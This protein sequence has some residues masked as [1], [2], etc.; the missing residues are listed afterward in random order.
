MK[1]KLLFSIV[2]VI[3]LS[4]CT[5]FH[6]MQ[7]DIHYTNLYYQDAIASYSKVLEKKSDYAVTQRLADCYTRT[8]DKKM[9]EATWRKAVAYPQHVHSDLYKFGLALMQVKKYEEAKLVFGKYLTLV[10]SDRLA[11]HRIISCDS[12]MA[13]Q[14]DSFLYAVTKVGGPLNNEVSNYSP[15]WYGDGIVFTS[16][17]SADPNPKIAEWTHHPYTDL[18]EAKLDGDSVRVAPRQLDGTI[19]GL[20]HEG[21]VVFTADQKFVYFTRSNYLKRHRGK[22]DDYVNNLKLYQAEN[23][24]GMWM[25]IIELPFNSDE[26]SSGHPALTKDEQEMYFVSDR[27]GGFGGTDLW[28]VRKAG[29]GWGTPQNL[30]KAI[31][32]AGNEMFPWIGTDNHLYFASDGWPGLGGLDVFKISLQPE[33]NQP[34]SGVTARTAEPMNMKYPLNSPRDDFG[35]IADD[36]GKTGYFSSNRNRIEGID[37][38]FYF[39]SVPVVLQLE[40]DVVTVKGQRPVKDAL[41]ELRFKSGQAIIAVK[42]DGNGHFSFPLEQSMGYSIHAARENM[43][44]KSDTL[45]TFGQRRSRTY[46]VLLEL[47]S[48][49]IGKP[50]VLKNIYYDFDKWD[51]RLDAEPD[52][53]QL[54][55]VMIDNPEIYVELGSHTDCR[56]T[57]K[58]NEKLSQKRAQSAVDYIVAHGIA[59]ERI[60]AKGYGEKVPVNKCVDGIQCDEPAHQ[61][62]RR[63]EFK[64]VKVLAPIVEE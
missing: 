50:I 38:I 39:V 53:N 13:Y 10:P 27:P 63:T 43:F 7:G 46:Y 56:G 15:A 61:E 5:M 8:G 11:T 2:L 9:A 44:G 23:R 26:F 30:G 54:V 49:E 3:G 48:L 35:Y 12:V 29:A 34:E 47:D 51:I 59:K 16:E 19:D 33:V 31:N 42:T 52:L 21:P 64:V 45:S 62:N 20:Y 25:D 22:S 41:V 37:D 6:R 32:T 1:M 14:Q 60:Y 18:Y 4:G 28:K 58:Y 24:S 57:R 40:G 55:S 17:R 36:D